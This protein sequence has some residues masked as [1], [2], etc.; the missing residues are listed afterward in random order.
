MTGLRLAC[1]IMLIV[2]TEMSQHGAAERK[3][4]NMV[5]RAKGSLFK[6]SSKQ[7]HKNIIMK[8]VGCYEKK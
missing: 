2:K 7:I 8:L 3:Y 1:V 5:L 4:G 6:S